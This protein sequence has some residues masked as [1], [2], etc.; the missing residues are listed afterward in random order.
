MLESTLTLNLQK[1]DFR[2]RHRRHGP[3]RQRR[4]LRREAARAAAAE[5]ADQA[6]EKAEPAAKTAEAAEN[7][8]TP[9]AVNAVPTHHHNQVVAEEAQPGLHD[10]QNF[11]SVL[12]ELCPDRVYHAAEQVAHQPPQFVP[13]D[14][15]PQH[16]PQVDGL[17]YA[18]REWWCY[19]CEYAKLFDTE[20]LLH[21]HHDDPDHFVTYE[22]CNICYP[23]HVWT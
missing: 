14:P 6:V 13:P 16:I 8:V 11:R 9:T 21:Q 7:D 22:E 23:W 5:T 1:L 2:P 12:D 15:P 18:E 10:D 4:R 19:C 20:E 3:A 17:D